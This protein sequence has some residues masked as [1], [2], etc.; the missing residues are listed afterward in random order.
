[1]KRILS[2]TLAAFFIISDAYAGDTI[3]EHVKFLSADIGKRNTSNYDSLQRAA[4]YIKEEFIKYGYD[5]EEQ[6]YHMQKKGFRDKP[7]RNIIA[8]KEG[9]GRKDKIIIIC[10]HYDT[11]CEAPGADDNASGVAAVLELARRARDVDLDKTVKFIAFTNEEVD[12][13][14]D[15]PDTGSYRYAKEAKATHEDIEAVLCIDMIGYYSDEPGSQKYPL[16]FKFFYPDKGNFIGICAETGSS[17]LLRKVVD[18]FKKASDMPVEYMAAPAPLV[19]E[20]VTS[21]NRAFW[22]FGYEAVW[23]SDTCIYRNPYMHTKGDTYGTL[24]YQRMSRVVDGLYK[25]VLKLAGKGALYGE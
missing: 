17:N 16:I 22:T 6:S 18:E 23:F 13:L 15:D 14:F 2:I 8:V 3:R 10:A 4:D 19:P 9:S 5:P 25:V 24:D 1:M 7:Y 21:D 12:I 20:L 11:Y